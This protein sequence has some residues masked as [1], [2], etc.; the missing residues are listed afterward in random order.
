MF[1]TLTQ[2]AESR[3]ITRELPDHYPFVVSNEYILSIVQKWDVPVRSL[4]DTIQHVLFA[5]VK[6]LVNKHFEK[7]TQGN[8]QHH[9]LY[10]THRV[11][12]FVPT[13]RPSQGDRH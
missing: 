4:F 12:L 8:L 7:F 5:H 6:V 11:S 10:V 3:A 2:P 9:V 1:V 13:H